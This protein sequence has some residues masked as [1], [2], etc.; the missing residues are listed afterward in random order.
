MTAYVFWILRV[1]AA[2][3]G[4]L[5]GWFLS[6]PLV[7]ILYRAARQ[8]PAPNWLVGWSKLGGAALL[9]FLAYYFLPLGGGGG[10]GWGP[11]AGG[12]PGLGPGDGSAKVEGNTS[13]ATDKQGKASKK[14]LALEIELL[15]G[16]N[17]QGDGR[18]Y[19][20]NR[21]EPALNL[22]EV[23]D[24]IQKN[25]ERLEP[26]IS[27]VLT[28]ASVDESHAAVLRL[29]TL[30]EKYHRTRQTKYLDAAPGK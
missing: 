19:L 14:D 8:K 12:G 7:R 18:Y 25:E 21:K 13:T 9:A 17:Y 10:L 26:S 27:V 29:N 20:L 1:A 6:G 3:G 5:L 23:E 28:P 15:G 2:L 16:K 22:A 11:G 4:A 30:I 24:Y